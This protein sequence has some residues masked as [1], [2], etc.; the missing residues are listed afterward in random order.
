MMVTA[1]EVDAKPDKA[2]PTYDPLTTPYEVDGVSFPET[3]T[4]IEQ[5]LHLVRYAILAPSTHNTQPWKFRLAENGIAVFADYARRLPVVDPD[6]RELLIS[7]GAAIMNLR[8]AAVHFG[9]DVGVEYNM[10]G[11]SEMPIAFVQLDRTAS[12]KPSDRQLDKL[13][14]V[15]A[16]R[17]TNRHPFL[18]MRVPEAVL[19][20]LSEAADGK[21]VNLV[22]STDPNKN[23]QVA[24]LVAEAE[25]ILQ[26][27]PEYRKELG[28]WMRPNATQKPDGMTGAAFGIGDLPSTLAPWAMKNLNLGGVR[29]RHDE[30]LCMEA[31]ALAVLCAEDSVPAWLEVGEVLQRVLLTIVR[32]GLHYSFFNMPIE[33]PDARAQLRKHLG[34]RLWPQLLLRIGY[35]L[36]Q[37][38]PTPRRSA[39]ECI[40]L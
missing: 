20:R 28:E 22:F 21:E 37:P 31:P 27:Q 39:E 23:T 16:K 34:V 5:M 15:I 36:E 12:A 4:M 19:G 40:V 26:A 1:I 7:L 24:H 35:C 14:P 17:H 3:G 25:R 11:D 18:I 9:F 2:Q 29:G 38:A 30:R 13:F 33:L 8:I 10:S 6:N 32:E